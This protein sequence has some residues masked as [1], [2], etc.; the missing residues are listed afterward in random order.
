MRKDPRM[1]YSVIDQAAVD[2]KRMEKKARKIDGC[3]VKHLFHYKADESE[4]YATGFLCDCDSCL[5]FALT[6]ASEK[7]PHLK[8]VC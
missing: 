4:I 6:I 7:K 8:K 3:M 5:D 2:R 1:S